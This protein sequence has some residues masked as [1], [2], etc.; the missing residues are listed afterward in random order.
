MTRR[1][2]FSR[3]AS[4]RRDIHAVALVGSHARGTAHGRHTP[5]PR[6]NVFCSRPDT[7]S[8]PEPRRNPTNA[9]PN[10]QV[11]WAR[12]VRRIIRIR[13]AS[14]ADFWTRC[15]R[16]GGF[17]TP[18]APSRSSLLLHTGSGRIKS[19]HRI[20]PAPRIAWAQASLVMDFHL[21]SLFWLALRR[22]ASRR[23]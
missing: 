4:E 7:R 12:K 11:L 16:V 14:V 8:N 15:D 17:S 18:S 23:P 3:W 13:R 22:H 6:T 5:S 10:L 1:L 19:K 20:A 2:A 9:N 21:L